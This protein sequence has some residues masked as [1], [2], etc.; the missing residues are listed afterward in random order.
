ME[1][2]RR[3]PWTIPTLLTVGSLFALLAALAGDGFWDITS[4][5]LLFL[6]IA[7]VGVAYFGRSRTK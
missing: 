4:W 5:L 1:Q 7:I 3:S 2:L 6:P